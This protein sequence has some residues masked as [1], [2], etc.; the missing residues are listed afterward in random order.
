MDKYLNK[1]KPNISENTVHTDRD[2]TT[3]RNRNVRSR[4]SVA[5]LRPEI[6][7][8]GPCPWRITPPSD[9]YK[10]GFHPLSR[11][12]RSKLYIP[13]YNAYISVEDSREMK[14]QLLQIWKPDT[15]IKPAEI[16]QK[17]DAFLKQTMTAITDHIWEN[18]GDPVYS[19]LFRNQSFKL[20]KEKVKLAIKLRLRGAQTELARLEEGNI[21]PSQLNVVT[22]LLWWE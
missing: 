3:E 21:S 9:F 10:A 20:S 8:A 12:M 4:I 18:K 14:R 6:L 15:K 22:R 1:H 11:I 19:K 2:T 16:I 7:W 17:I 5:I 13:A